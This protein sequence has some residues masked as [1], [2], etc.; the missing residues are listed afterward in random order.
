MG[1]FGKSKKE[2]EE[3]QEWIDIESA[4]NEILKYNPVKPVIK[5]RKRKKSKAKKRK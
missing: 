5:Q 4:A 3:E 1:L 2:K